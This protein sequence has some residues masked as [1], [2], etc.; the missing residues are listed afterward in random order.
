MPFFQKEVL[1]ASLEIK[2]DIN[3]ELIYVLEIGIILKAFIYFVT[4]PSKLIYKK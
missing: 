3:T 4:K 1:F 2:I